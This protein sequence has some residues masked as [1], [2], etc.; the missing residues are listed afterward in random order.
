[1]LVRTSSFAGRGWRTAAMFWNFSKNCCDVVSGFHH[2]VPECLCE[3]LKASALGAPVNATRA[4]RLPA[5]CHLP[6]AH[7]SGMCAVL[8]SF[9]FLVGLRLPHC[10]LVF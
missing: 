4:S 6:P 3:V 10:R 2:L 9:L 5:F 1:M 7:G 8:P